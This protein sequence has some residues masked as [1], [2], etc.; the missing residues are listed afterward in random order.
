MKIGVVLV[1]YNRLEK[2]KIAIK[3][4][5]NQIVRPEYIMIVNNCSTDGTEQFLEEWQNE[6]TEIE[7]IVINLDKNT[8][9]SGGFNEGLTNCLALD[10]DWVWVADDD[11]YPKENAF[12]IAQNYIQKYPDLSPELPK[13]PISANP[14]VSKNPKAS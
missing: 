6:K 10:A 7:K 9:G 4:Y 14:V 11:A 3:S 1:T 13:S 8:G 12:A 5:E 2:L